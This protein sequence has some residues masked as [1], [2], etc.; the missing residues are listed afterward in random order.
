MSTALYEWIA[1]D[2]ALPAAAG[3]ALPVAPVRWLLVDPGPD[4][5]ATLCAAAA[6]EAGALIDVSGRWERIHLDNPEPLRAGV[7]LDLVLRERRCA[8]TWIF[9]CPVLLARSGA[10]IDCWIEASYVASF[11]AMLERARR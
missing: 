9:D 1:F 11:T 6:A 3:S 10:G 8:A 7:A 5:L 4:C 2:G